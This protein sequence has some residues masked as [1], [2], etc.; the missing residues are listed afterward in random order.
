MFQMLVWQLQHWRFI[1]WLLCQCLFEFIVNEKWSF[2]NWGEISIWEEKH[3]SEKVIWMFNLLVNKAKDNF[4]MDLHWGDVQCTLVTV[5]S[6]LH[7]LM[8]GL[9]ILYEW[10]LG[11]VWMLSVSS[12]D[13]FY[14]LVGAPVHTIFVMSMTD[15]FRAHSFFRK[16][17]SVECEPH[18][19]EVS[20]TWLGQLAAACS[21]WQTLGIYKRLP[22]GQVELHLT[23]CVLHSLLFCILVTSHI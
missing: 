6:C 20:W 19:Q 14:W 1:S 22:L 23:Q 5:F 9:Y 15:S 16:L 21:Q 13:L 3:G 11:F 10:T 4:L 17:P 18:C 2:S 12:S 7:T 8:N